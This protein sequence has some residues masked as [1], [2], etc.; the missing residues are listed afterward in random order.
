MYNRH[1][2]N[3][4]EYLILSWIKK[5]Y[6][7]PHTYRRAAWRSDSRLCSCAD[8]Q[9]NAETSAA[10][11]QLMALFCFIPVLETEA[12]NSIGAQ[13]F[14]LT[15]TNKHFSFGTV[16]DLAGQIMTEKGSN[17]FSCLY[18]ARVKEMHRHPLCYLILISRWSCPWRCFNEKH[19]QHDITFKSESSFL[20]LI[21]K[22]MNLSI[23]NIFLSLGLWFVCLKT[24][25]K[26]L[27]R[28]EII[29][30]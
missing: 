17:A 5:P 21:S 6:F 12:I 23:K 25:F 3:P 30:L 2:E 11:L 9:H 16:Q 4:N 24:F 26:L 15:R 1:V 22:I 14:V 20:S 13:T 29:F 19:S 28:N 8:L 27:L 7:F 10:H 18:M